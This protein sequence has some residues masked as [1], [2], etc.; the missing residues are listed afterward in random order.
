MNGE[1]F[2]KFQQK[3][4][5]VLLPISMKLGSQRHLAAIRDGMA[6]L[7]PLTIIGG[8]SILLAQPPINP[9]TMANSNFF[10]SLLLGWYNWAQTY[11]SILFIPFN[12]TIGL[13][14]VYVVTAIAYRLSGSYG[15]PKLEVSFIALVTFL[16]VAAA[17]EAFETGNYLPAANLGASGMFIAM[18]VAI[19]VV[20]ITNVCFK[21]NLT[22][23]LPDSVPP[24]IASPFKILIPM[25]INVIG[26]ILLN[27][28]CNQL[29]GGGLCDLLMKLLEPL[30]SATESLPSILFLLIL[31]NL[32]WFFGIHGDN[33]IGGVVTPITTMNVA[34]NLEAYTQGREM[35]HIFAGQFN[36]VWG[37]WTVYISLLISLWVVAKSQQLVSLRKL[38]PVATAFNINEPQIFGIPV[39]LNITLLIPMMLCLIINVCTAYALTYF[40][41]IGKVYM[42]LPWTTPAPIAA[43]LSTMDYKALILWFVLTAVDV[44]IMCPFVKSYDDTLVMKE[45]ENNTDTEKA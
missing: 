35:T 40:D 41:I 9:E 23:K 19:V 12:L 21:K 4:E 22:I 33:M 29:T 24:N 11:S 3:L 10:F 42:V 38:A 27:A 39:V 34:L 26:F 5:K 18:I 44:A 15:L 16:C 37:T 6:I 14:S 32:F 25:V 2:N 8:V 1:L 28:W 45:N 30:L 20:E 7:I 36:G 13:L 43:F 31:S 17:P